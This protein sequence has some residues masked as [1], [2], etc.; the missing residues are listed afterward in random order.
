MRFAAVHQ[1]NKIL[2]ATTKPF[3]QAGFLSHLEHLS[4]F[5]PFVADAQ[6]PPLLGAILMAS[7]GRGELS[8]AGACLILVLKAQKATLQAASGTD[9]ANDE[10]RRYQKY[11]RPGQPSSHIVQLR[12][13]QAAAR[14]ASNQS[15]QSFIKAA[16]A[17]VSEAAIKVP[18]RVALE[19]FMT[20]WI[21]AN[22]P[23]EFLSAAD[24]P[25]QIQ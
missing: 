16:A 5:A 8:K 14:Q 15:K 20:G 10:L 18:P 24:F 13:K 1:G 21:D 25:K 6:L 2:M 22:V 11:A 4:E 9:L 17:F 23:K 3:L 19:A 12:Q 7:D